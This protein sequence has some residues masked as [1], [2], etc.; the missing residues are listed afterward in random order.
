MTEKLIS[1]F[2]Q[3]PEEQDKQRYKEIQT[4]ISLRLL[5]EYPQYEARLYHLFEVMY[6]IS[7]IDIL[8]SFDDIPMF[9][10]PKNIIKSKWVLPIED[11]ESLTLGIDDPQMIQKAYQ[12]YAITNKKITLVFIR[13]SIFTAYFI[14]YEAYRNFHDAYQ[15]VSKD[16]PIYT[17]PQ[18]ALDQEKP[19]IKYSDQLLFMSHA[20]HASDIHLTQN[21][22]KG[23]VKYRIHGLLKTYQEHDVSLHHALL[24]RY[25][26]LSKLHVGIEQ[27]PQDGMFYR[28][29]HQGKHM[30]RIASIPTFHGEHMVIRVI[31]DQHL[32]QHISQLGLNVEHEQLLKENLHIKQG[33]ILLAGATGSGKSTTLHA[34]IR[35]LKKHVEHV[36]TL[37]DPIENI[38]DDATQITIGESSDRFYEKALKHILRLDPDIVMIGEIRDETS[39][40][41]AMKAALT[42]HIVLST[43]HANSPEHII[44]RL[45]SFHLSDSLQHTVKMMIFQTLI[46]IQCNACKGKGCHLC[47]HTGVIE[48]QALFEIYTFNQHQKQWIKKGIT[49]RDAVHKL[50][51]TGQISLETKTLFINSFE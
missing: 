17:T 22:E 15:H 44:E 36:I 51:E 19:F 13:R 35:H 43:I 34:V 16:L 32:F 7:C 50:Y 1:Y 42:G 45:K 38:I 8:P 30:Y 40:K 2:K 31:D 20:L 5:D 18:L 4:H 11:T 3:V 24:R 39:A 26:V 14:E 37:E 27:M 6:G 25:K 21:A 10:L 28:E 47:K 48:R 29:D 33:L 49:I 46:P 23:F 41:V 12:L 9:I